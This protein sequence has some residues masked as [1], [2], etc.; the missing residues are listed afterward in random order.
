MCMRM[1]WLTQRRLGSQSPARPLRRTRLQWLLSTTRSKIPCVYYMNIDNSIFRYSQTWRVLCRRTYSG[2]HLLRQPFRLCFRQHPSL[3]PEA[4]TT[5]IRRKSE[6]NTR[7][8]RWVLLSRR[9]FW[10]CGVL[11][12]NRF[13]YITQTPCFLECNRNRKFKEPRVWARIKKNPDV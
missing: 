1:H 10:I 7:T 13:S 2:F 6:V 12:A 9:V 4:T 11:I 3:T 8:Q 5:T